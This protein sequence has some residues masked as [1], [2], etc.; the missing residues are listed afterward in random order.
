MKLLQTIASMNATGGGTSSCTYQL[1]NALYNL[2]PEVRLLSMAPKSSDTEVLGMA[3]NGSSTYQMI[4]GHLSES[5]KTYG[6][7]LKI[8]MRKSS[9]PMEC[10]WTSIMRLAL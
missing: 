4:I 1:F 8:P 9:I 3:L 5:R 10:G 6:S 7:I 2:D